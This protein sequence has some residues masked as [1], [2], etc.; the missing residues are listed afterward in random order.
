MRFANHSSGSA[1]AILGA[2]AVAVVLFAC[3]EPLPAP[4]DAPV[5]PAYSV[6]GTILTHDN[7]AVP[8]LDV[9]VAL[10][11]SDGETSVTTS[12]DGA[13]Q[14]AV[15]MSGY[16]STCEITAGCGSQQVV[17]DEFALCAESPDVV[18]SLRLYNPFG[19]FNCSSSSYEY[20]RCVHVGRPFLRLEHRSDRYMTASLTIDAYY[21]DTTLACDTVW[22]TSFVSMR[23]SLGKREYFTWKANGDGVRVRNIALTDS[24]PTPYN[25]AT[26][27]GHIAMDG[28]AI[29]L[30][31]Y[32]VRLH[33]A[34]ATCDANGDFVLRSW[35]TGTDTLKIHKGKALLWRQNIVLSGLDMDLGLNIGVRPADAEMACSSWTVS[36]FDA[37]S[38]RPRTGQKCYY[39]SGP[40]SYSS[41]VAA[42][43]T[44]YAVPVVKDTWLTFWYR[45][46]PKGSSAALTVLY[47]ADSAV[48]RTT[49][50][51]TALRTYSKYDSLWTYEAIDLSALAGSAYYL[52][53]LRSSSYSDTH[54]VAL[55]DIRLVRGASLATLSRTTVSGTA[56]SANGQPLADCWVRID[57]DSTRVNA[58]GAYSLQ[59]AR[60]RF[61]Q[62]RATISH[63][64]RSVH[65]W[66][67]SLDTGRVESDIL[68]PWFA[69]GA[70]VDTASDLVYCGGSYSGRTSNYEHNGQYCY[71]L[72]CATSS[73]YAGW[74]ATKGA[75]PLLGPQ[76][77]LEFWS[78][79]QT[80]PAP[81]SFGVRIDAVVDGTSGLPVDTVYRGTAVDT[82]LGWKRHV[83]PLPVLSAA[84][85]GYA[86]LVFTTTVSAG[87][88]VFL[89]DDVRVLG[90][91][92]LSM[93]RAPESYGSV[94]RPLRARVCGSSAHTRTRGSPTRWVRMRVRWSIPDGSTSWPAGRRGSTCSRCRYRPVA[95]KST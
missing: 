77:Y 93:G 22:R 51:W 53:F 70:E 33:D 94:Q 72:T 1:K 41:S 95:G 7:L 80:S 78:R 9:T 45:V 58:A 55:D 67:V 12:T 49:G 44:N 35:N 23:G 86:R 27:R 42:I 4:E 91:A 92:D 83:V 20:D 36:E 15:G 29:D 26:I 46:R 64:G 85:G 61:G 28:A 37:V 40:R 8:E 11:G 39:T 25:G 84:T 79:L 5:P 34:I 63:S 73:G 75:V 69:V 32:T 82:V 10:S 87:S 17:S 65:Q 62:C 30:S 31:G 52:G 50:N 21:T 56:L 24:G 43:S 76:Q 66:L 2:A 19:D 68:L 3:A 90:T 74:L 6:S 60:S 54:Y 89:L 59:S 88:Q 13:G 18:R 57:S 16:Y 38:T 71:A 14:Y 81:T 48:A 47:T